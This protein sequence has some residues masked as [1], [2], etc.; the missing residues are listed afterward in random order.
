MGMFLV[1]DNGSMEDL[2]T[3]PRNP[4]P[5]ATGASSRPRTPA[6]PSPPPSRATSPRPRTCAA[7]PSSSSGEVFDVPLENNVFR[8]AAVA[9]LFGQRQLYTA[10]L[11]DGQGG[12]RPPDLG[13][14]GEGRP[15][16]PVHRQPGRGV[17]RADARQPLGHRRPRRPARGRRLPEPPQSLGPD[18]ARERHPPLPDRPRRRHDRLRDPGL[19]LHRDPGHLHQ[20]APELP[21]PAPT[22]PS[23]ASIRRGTTHK[24]ETEGVGPSASNAVADHLTALLDQSPDPAAE[25]R[26]G[27]FIHARTPITPRLALQAAHDTRGT[28]PSD[29]IGVWLADPGL[30]RPRRQQ[31]HDRRPGRLR[32]PSDHAPSMRFGAFMDFDGARA[33]RPRRLHPGDVDPVR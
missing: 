11:P 1:G 18:L 6:R 19:G 7:A 5:D 24:L 4:D 9:G 32:A 20:P 27:R 33:E 12:A 26:L 29:A 8:A 23:P 16:P 13:R 17:P 2:K 22:I 14:G 15:G 3:N 21:T 30:H 31:R 28:R 25:F 10:G